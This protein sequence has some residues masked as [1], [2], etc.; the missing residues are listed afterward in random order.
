MLLLWKDLQQSSNARQH[1]RTADTKSDILKTHVKNCKDSSFESQQMMPILPAASMGTDCTDD[2]DVVGSNTDDDC[3]IPTKETKLD[4]EDGTGGEDDHEDTIDDNDYEYSDDEVSGEKNDDSLDVHIYFTNEIPSTSRVKKAKSV[5][6]ELV[7]PGAILLLS[8]SRQEPVLGGVSLRWSHSLG[9]MVSRSSKVKVD[10]ECQGHQ[11]L[12]WLTRWTLVDLARVGRVGSLLDPPAIELWTSY[13]YGQGQGHPE[14]IWELTERNDRARFAYEKGKIWYTCNHHFYLAAK[15]LSCQTKSIDLATVFRLQCSVLHRRSALHC[16]P[17]SLEACLPFPSPTSATTPPPLLER[18]PI[19]NTERLPRG[20]GRYNME[21]SALVSLLALWS[22][23]FA[24]PRPEL[25]LDSLLGAGP[26]FVILAVDWVF[27]VLESFSWG[28]YGSTSPTIVTNL[29]GCVSLGTPVKIHAGRAGVAERLDCSPPTEANRVQPPTRSLPVF[30]NGNRGGRCRLW[31]GFLGDVPFSPSF[32]SGAA[33]FS[34]HFTYIGSQDLFVKSRLTCCKIGETMVSAVQVQKLAPTGTNGVQLSPSTVTADNQCVVDIGSFV[35]KTA[36]S[37]LQATQTKTNFKRR[38]WRGGKKLAKPGASHPNGENEPLTKIH[39][40]E[41]RPTVKH[42]PTLLLPAFYWF[43]VKQGVSKEV[44]S[45]HSCR[46]KEQ[47]FGSY[48]ASESIRETLV[49]LTIVYDGSKQKCLRIRISPKRGKERETSRDGIGEVR[50]S[51]LPPIRPDPTIIHDSEESEEVEHVFSRT[52]KCAKVS[53]KEMH[54]FLGGVGHLGWRGGW[55]SAAGVGENLENGERRRRKAVVDEAGVLLSSRGRASRRLCVQG[56][57]ADASRP[58]RESVGRLAKLL[59]GIAIPPPPPFPNNNSTRILTTRRLPPRR[60]GFQSP[61]GPLRIFACGNRAGRCRWSGGFS[62]GSP[63]PPAISFRRCVILTSFTCIGSQDLDVTSRPNIFTHSRLAQLRHRLRGMVHESII[64]AR[65]LSQDNRLY[66]DS[67]RARQRNDVDVPLMCACP[68]SYWMRE[69]LGKS[70]ESDWL[71]RTARSIPCWLK[72]RCASRVP[73]APIVQRRSRPFLANDA[74]LVACAVGVCGIGG[75]FASLAVGSLD[76]SPVCLLWREC[77]FCT[78]LLLL[79][80]GACWRGNSATHAAREHWKRFKTGRARKGDFP[81]F[82]DASHRG[83]VPP[84]AMPEEQLKHNHA[85]LQHSDHSRKQ[86][87][88]PDT[89]A[90]TAA[91]WGR[92][93]KLFNHKRATSGCTVDCC[94]A[95]QELSISQ[96]QAGHLFFMNCWL[97]SGKTRVALNHKRATSGCTVDCCLANQELPISQPQAGHLFFMNCWLMSGKTRVALN[98][99]RATSGC[100]VDCCLANQEL[101]ISQPQVGHLFFMNCWLMSGKTRVAL[102]HKRATSGCTVDCCLANQELS[103]S[104]PQAGHFWM[105]CRL[106]SGKPRVAHKST[107]SGPLILHELLADVWENKSCP[108]LE[109]GVQLSPSTVTADNQC[110][111]NIDIFVHKPLDSSLQHEPANPRLH[112]LSVRRQVRGSIESGT[113]AKRRKA[114]RRDAL[115]WQEFARIC[116]QVSGRDRRECKN[117]NG[118]EEEEAG[119]GGGE[120]SETKAPIKPLFDRGHVAMHQT[121]KRRHT[122]ITSSFW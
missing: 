25:H 27:F 4:V 12:T 51:D 23:V 50:M 75:C 68:F 96:P 101:S 118:R 106:L 49:A 37:S 93:T 34:S 40:V 85:L 58:P 121:R 56:L 29:T 72:W 46:R 107:T 44:S 8:Q 59:G 102:N 69:Y 88:S 67:S 117:C 36:E 14:P 35:H 48:L 28:T 119:G 43:T 7:S 5:L 99:K 13:M 114:R 113:L 89:E 105:Y 79:D 81:V 9:S 120:V 104:Q 110:A 30:A 26:D 38:A 39:E 55:V 53:L 66:L 32:Q 103:I 16:S 115:R 15:N 65:F 80:G 78:S 47:E 63:V 33:P 11:H 76:V 24:H 41:C 100:T 92:S 77:D 21:E 98:H 57:R 20:E 94:L 73:A 60:S 97:M 95:N 10:G 3:A 17:T 122:N 45:N 22:S 108:H 2:Y 109:N 112:L 62:R 42:S 18:A 71:V 82:P 19:F 64:F 61:A 54:S 111:V 86:W 6:Q 90:N 52:E 91:K 1:Y 116:V 84:A 87:D 70:L 31:V 74:I 83:A